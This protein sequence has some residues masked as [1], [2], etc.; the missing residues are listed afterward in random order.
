LTEQLGEI[1]RQYLA[2]RH[3]NRSEGQV[4]TI[5]MMKQPA[6]RQASAAA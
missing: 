2:E 3:H 6:R 5:V 4:H 1:A